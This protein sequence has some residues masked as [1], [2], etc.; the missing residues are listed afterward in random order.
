MSLQRKPGPSILKNYSLKNVCPQKKSAYSGI[1]VIISS[2]II[3]MLTNPNK[4]LL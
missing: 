2:I 4:A 3:I 1:I